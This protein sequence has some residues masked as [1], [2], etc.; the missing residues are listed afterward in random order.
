M[1]YD[2]IA[3]LL[4]AAHPVSGAWSQD[5]AAIADQFNVKDIVRIRSSMSG[6]EVFGTTV[7]S[8]FSNLSNEKRQLWMSFCARPQI[9]PRNSA[10]IDTVEFIF[11]NPSDTLTALS[12]AR[13]EMIS[14]ATR[15]NLGKVGE[16][17]TQKVRT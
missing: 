10:N 5:N 7:K 6:D 12:K 14:L 9:D 16:G 4:G 15:E 1:D 13:K 17:H 8:E 2:K 11:G 3:T